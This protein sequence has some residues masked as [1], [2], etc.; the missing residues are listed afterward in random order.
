VDPQIQS[1][2]GAQPLHNCARGR[3]KVPKSNGLRAECLGPLSFRDCGL[4]T[5]ILLPHGSLGAAQGLRAGLHSSNSKR[6]GA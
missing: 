3:G 6:A 2:P 5:S 4:T 1:K